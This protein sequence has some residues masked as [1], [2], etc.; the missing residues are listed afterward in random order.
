MNQDQYTSINYAS[1]VIKNKDKNIH[2]K[3]VLSQYYVYSLS[4]DTS[5]TSMP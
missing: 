3:I 1:I 2:D 4:V 5:N